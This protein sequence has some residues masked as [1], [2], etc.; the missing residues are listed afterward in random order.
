MRIGI[1][2]DNTIVSYDILFHRVAVERGIVPESLSQTK[3]AVRDHLRS[4]GKEDTWTEMQGYVYG[5]R[6]N[7]A[8]TYPGVLDFL[9]WARAN[10][11]LVSVI[12]HKTRYP[13]LG[14][15]YDLHKAARQW[16]ELRL[17]DDEGWLV[18]PQ[19]VFFELT[20][21]AKLERIAAAQ[22]HYFVDDL[23]E[24]LLASGFPFDTARILFDPE[25]SHASA[26]G[27]ERFARWDEIQRYFECQ[28]RPSH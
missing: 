13:F 3:L 26:G 18:E 20:K 12:S 9:R 17:V 1:D 11:I 28:C 21:E 24:L 4:V 19:Q 7:D 16:A 6:M 27:L 25:E 10:G 15:Q 2:F 22:C 23:P 8:E 14:P 5:A